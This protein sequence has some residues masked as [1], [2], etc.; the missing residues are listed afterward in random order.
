MLILCYFVANTPPQK[1]VKL[2]N[3]AP[4]TPTP[5]GSVGGASSE[6]PQPGAVPVGLACN[7][8]TLVNQVGVVLG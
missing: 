2:E 1:K 3:S 6:G 5:R 8:S 7:S 4:D